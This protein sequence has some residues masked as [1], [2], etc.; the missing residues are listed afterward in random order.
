MVCLDTD[1]LIELARKDAAAQERLAKSA[2]K[3][4]VVYTTTINVAEFYA[5]IY[6]SKK[7][8]SEDRTNRF[9]DSFAI[10]TLDNESAKLCGKLMAQMRSNTIGDSDLII[11]SIVISSNQTLITKN[12]KHFGRIPG[13]QMDDW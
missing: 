1:F 6:N 3:G 10:I 8:W 4:E 11:A 13:L 12:K 5:G 2:K 7:G 9:F